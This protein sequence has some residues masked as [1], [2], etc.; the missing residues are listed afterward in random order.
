MIIR[1][2]DTSVH[3]DDV[4]RGKQIFR[5]Q[6]KPAF[7]RFP[8]CHGVEMYIGVEEHSGELVEVVAISKWDSLDDITKAVTTDE[9]ADALSELKLLFKQ[10]PIVRHFETID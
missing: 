8:G 2:F 10:A 5:E 1:I 7:D 4:E 3:P 9:Y 6:T